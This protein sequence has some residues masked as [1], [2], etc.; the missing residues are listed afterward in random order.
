MQ[1]LVV[2]FLV[3]AF[4]SIEGFPRASQSQAQR[5][6]EFIQGARALS[7]DNVGKSAVVHVGVGCGG[8]LMN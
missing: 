4:S 6:Q 1:Y 7:K 8:F 2:G 3:W 5:N